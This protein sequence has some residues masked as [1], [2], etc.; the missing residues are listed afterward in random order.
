M[1]FST[2]SV[3]FRACEFRSIW[4][5]TFFVA[6]TL[7]SLE[8]CSR[9]PAAVHV[10]EVDPVESSKQAFEL[11]DTDNDG[12]LSDTELA[13]CPGIQM[14]LQLYDKDSDGSVSQQE[15]EEQLN[16]LVSGQIGVTSLR[17]QV[18]LD[19]RPLPGAQIKLVPEMY[20]GDDVN[21]AY[22]T[23]NGR[24]TATMDIRDEDSPASDHGLLGV[25]Y[26]TYKV[27]VT[28]PE[29]SIP[30]KY[31]TQTTLGYETEKGNPSFV[32]NLKS[33]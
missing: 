3:S 6:F 26:G 30:E 18:R 17:I 22:G 15:L 1:K 16:S 13:A 5:L 25:H 19:G 14:H 27:E 32:L 28:H 33:R 9:G 31:N 11:Y 21:V 20:L 7:I 24:G 10:P 23:T 29:A 2:F 4:L 8:G 12:Q